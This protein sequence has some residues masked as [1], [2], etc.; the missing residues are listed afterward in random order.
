MPKKGL[1]Q[2]ASAISRVSGRTLRAVEP[3]VSKLLRSVRMVPR[4][5]DMIS[6][7]ALF[8][9]ATFGGTLTLA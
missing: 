6:C 5:P 4:G 3:W 2:D 7:S 1:E 9:T 8:S